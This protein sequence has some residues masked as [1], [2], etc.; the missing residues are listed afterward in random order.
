MSSSSS[1]SDSESDSESSSEEETSSSSEEEEKGAAGSWE[2]KGKYVGE[3]P[4]KLNMK[5]SL[6]EYVC[7]LPPPQTVP[8]REAAR[9][10]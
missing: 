8:Q 7:H 3:V 10:G 2:A 1:E 6:M 5:I 9:P 4:Q